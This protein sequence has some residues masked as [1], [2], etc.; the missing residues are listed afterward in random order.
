MKNLD[1]YKN[2]R[3]APDYLL[4]YVV[5]I[6]LIAVVEQRAPSIYVTLFDTSQEDALNLNEKLKSLFNNNYR[7]PLK[8]EASIKYK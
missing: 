2:R 7:E 1:S 4:T 3:E 8:I 6:C 5:G